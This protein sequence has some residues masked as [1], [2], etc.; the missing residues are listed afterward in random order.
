M[1]DL[2]R[3]HLKKRI[4]KRV[5]ILPALLTLGNGLSGFGSVV[6]ASGKD[7]SS[8]ATAAWLIF[9]GMVFDA[10]DGKV[11]R[12]TKAAS[13]F[14]AQ[15]DSLCDVITFGLAP[16]FLA[17]RVAASPRTILGVNF[18]WMVCGLYLCCAVLRL[19]RFNVETTPDDAA[20]EE[21]KG[22][23]SPG[24]AGVVASYVLFYLWLAGEEPGVIS[25]FMPRLLP[26]CVLAAGL[27]M[28]SRFRYV[29]MVNRLFR[30]HHPFGGLIEVLLVVLL[31]AL[32]PQMTLCL[33]F[34]AYAAVGPYR[35]V[36]SRF[37][38][39]TEALPAG[40]GAAGAAS[41]GPGEEDEDD[42]E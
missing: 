40:G 29:H 8:M 5:A 1:R 4:L 6:L 13:N 17:T 42:E 22:L 38:P 33:A 7:P 31:I 28:I 16:A 18:V 23:P 2:P 14:G 11:A 27:L 26:F 10:L 3:L 9:L 41:A 36:R 37:G 32:N 12:M 21:F 39:R 34:L 15:L 24:A 20:H 35:W 30:G 19:A 25:G